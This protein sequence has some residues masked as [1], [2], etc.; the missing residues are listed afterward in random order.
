MSPEQG[1]GGDVDERSDL[2]SFGIVLY[3]LL[4]GVHPFTRDSPSATLAA[5]VREAPRPLTTYL[6]EAPA[7]LDIMVGTL[8]AKE[9][10]DRYQTFGDV[11][12]DLRRLREQLSTRYAGVTVREEPPARGATARTRY[13]GREAERADLRRWYAQMLLD[14]NAPGDCDRARRLV[15][16]AIN[17]YRAVGM[18]KHLALAE[19]MREQSD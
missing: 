19:R 18:P 9:P 11:A 16:E 12:N 13:A 5:I 10:G 6:K 15:G 7:S 4:A 8:L 14:R 3:E 1:L 17:M 2:F